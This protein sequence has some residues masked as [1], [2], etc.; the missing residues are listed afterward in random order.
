[1][2]KN[3]DKVEA[4]V[5]ALAFLHK[6]YQAD[7][8]GYILRNPILL[9][10]FAKPGK[11]EIT[12]EGIRVFDSLLGGYLAAVFDVKKKVS[13][14]SNSGI[15]KTDRLVN[16]LGVYGINQESEINTVVYFLRKA[17]QDPSITSKTPLSYFTLDK[18]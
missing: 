4:I 3:I 17:L 13:G 12:E 5:D 11:H 8:P 16:L 7:S 1:M 10:S 9:R 18:N 15:K 2:T 6:S 14:G